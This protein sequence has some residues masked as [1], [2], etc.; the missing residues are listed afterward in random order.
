MRIRHATVEDAESLRSMASEFFK[1][2]SEAGALVKPGERSVAWMMQV[3]GV[4]ISRAVSGAVLI[5]EDGETPVGFTAFY[6]EPVALEHEF[7]KVAKTFVN[8][9]RP[10]HRREGVASDLIA[11]KERLAK[12]FGCDAMYTTVRLNNEASLGLVRK[13]GYAAQDVTLVKVL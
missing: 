3:C 4:L 10:E 13:A 1:E 7:Q 11:A 6:V 5:A 9:V 8:Y 2:E 12:Q